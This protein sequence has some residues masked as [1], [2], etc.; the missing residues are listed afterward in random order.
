[1]STDPT[2]DKGPDFTKGVATEALADGSML[3]GHVGEDAVLL[4]RRGDEYFAIGA[5]CTHYHGPLAEGLVV[6]D[7]VRCPWHHACF[8]LRTG[9]ALRAPALSPVACW[10]IELRADKVVVRGKVVPQPASRGASPT[11]AAPPQRIVIVGGGAAGFAAAE[12]LRRQRYQGSIVML[13]DDDAPPVDRPNLSK[14]YLAGSAPEEWVPLRERGLL[15][16]AGHRPAPEGQRHRPRCARARTRTRTTAAGS[17]TTGCCW[18]PAPSRCAC[19]SPAQPAAR[20]HPAHAGR[21]PRHHR[22][23]GDGAKRRRDRGELHRPRGGRRA[24]H[25]RPRGARRGAGEA[26]DGARAG[27]GAG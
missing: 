7:T 26:P 11:A 17:P 24:A 25:A 13:S 19:P 16:R 12:M 14:D 3:A 4:A 10:A 22:A 27:P 2:P 1:M 20:A 9:E 15:R 8:N 5:E 21:Q 6:D 23:G 18:R